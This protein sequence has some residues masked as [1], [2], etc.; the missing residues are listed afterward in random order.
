ME[1]DLKLGVRMRERQHTNQGLALIFDVLY[2]VD[3]NIDLAKYYT[4]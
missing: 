2:L 1:N 4:C 3:M